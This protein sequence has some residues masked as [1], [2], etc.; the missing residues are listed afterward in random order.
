MF[1]KKRGLSQSKLAE[2]LACSSNNDSVGREHI[3]RWERGER[4]P[5]PYWRDW[6]GRVLN[7]PRDQLEH[8]AVVSR[9]VRVLR[10]IEREL[11]VER[12]SQ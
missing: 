7:V 6:L 4:I 10:Q 9:Q 2:K 3:S 11:L 5:N 1:R 8:A 12:C